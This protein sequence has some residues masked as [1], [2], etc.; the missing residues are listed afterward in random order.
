MDA[1][2]VSCCAAALA[3][4]S[5]ASNLSLRCKPSNDFLARDGLQHCCLQVSVPCAGGFQQGLSRGEGPFGFTCIAAAADTDQD[6]WLT[7]R[8]RVCSVIPVVIMTDGPAILSSSFSRWDL[9]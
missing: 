8:R 1:G 7:E 5:F 9:R 6:I 2:G 3:M 4:L